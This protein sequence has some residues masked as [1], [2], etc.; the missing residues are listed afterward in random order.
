MAMAADGFSQTLGRDLTAGELEPVNRIQVERAM[1]LTAV[2]LATAQAAAYALRRRV[3]QWWA[4]GW[5]LLLTPTLG[6]P[7]PLLSEFESDPDDP[8]APMR[9]AN[10]FV[11]FTPAFNVSG[12]PAISLPLHWNADGIPVGVQLVAAYGREDLLIRVAAQLESAHPWS[13]RHPPVT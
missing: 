3:Q 1:S 7:P 6:E 12:Q 2:D 4:D 11:P 8:A 5:D 13:D 10:G 9:R